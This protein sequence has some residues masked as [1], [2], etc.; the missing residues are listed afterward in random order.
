MLSSTCALAQVVTSNILPPAPEHVTVDQNNVNVSTGGISLAR[1]ELSIGSNGYGL[2]L[3][4]FYESNSGW[5][6]SFNGLLHV[7]TDITGVPAGPT[8][9]ASW[10]S[11][12]WSFEQWSDN[13]TSGDGAFLV[14]NTLTLRDGTVIDYSLQ[15]PGTLCETPD[16]PCHEF[17]V[18]TT[19]SYPNGLVLTLHYRSFTTSARLQSVTNNAGYQIKF[20]YVNNT[21][22][23]NVLTR[24]GATAINNAVE[25]C[26]P[27]AD[28][29][30]LSGNWPSVAYSNISDSSGTGSFTV[31]DSLNRAT[32]YSYTPTTFTIKSPGTSTDN[33]QYTRAFVQDVLLGSYVFRTTSATFGSNTWNYTYSSGTTTNPRTITATNA[34]NAATVYTSSISTDGTTLLSIKDPLNRTASFSYPCSGIVNGWYYFNPSQHNVTSPEGNA[35][36]RTCDSRGNV[37]SVT[38]QPKSGSGLVDISSSWT[39][40]ATCSN[41]KTCNKATAFVDGRGATTDYA[42]HST[43]GGL[44]TET[45]PAVDGV[46]PQKRYEYQQLYAYVKNS[47]GTLVAASSPVWVPTKVSQC[48]T[49]ASCTG[50]A[51]EI[52]TTYEYSPTNTANRLLVRGEVVTAGGVSRRT[53]YS[54]DEI[55]NRTAQTTPRAG[56]SVCL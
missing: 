20:T 42:Y 9:I 51:D 48:R 36:T 7:I 6:D 5:R 33:I 46:R 11:R 10:G 25:Y 21:G 17:F 18:P 23:G 32:R 24:T 37:T 45:E 47:G 14:N 27:T 35:T 43:H 12:G 55:G 4:R 39:F 38:L 49:T 29:C 50:G 8:R 2:E 30:S 56:L 28:S 15:V 13:S 16:A 52:V 34:Q 53:C 40:P 54:Y 44:M 41:T 3:A 31:T 22:P 26:N 19:V 1:T